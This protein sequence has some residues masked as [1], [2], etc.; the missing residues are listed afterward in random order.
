MQ[1]KRENQCIIMYYE[2]IIELDVNSCQISFYKLNKMGEQNIFLLFLKM[3]QCF[4]NSFE[5]TEGD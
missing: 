2:Q 5:R 1:E 3:T 4:I